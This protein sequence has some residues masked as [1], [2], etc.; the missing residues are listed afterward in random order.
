MCSAGRFEIWFYFSMAKSSFEPIAGISS[1]KFTFGHRFLGKSKIEIQ[2]FSDYSKKLRENGV[3][4]RFVDRTEKISK[5]LIHEA[6]KSGGTLAEDPDLLRIMA[7][8]VEYPE[9]LKGS[10]SPD[11]L[12]LPKEI[13]INAM[14]KHQKYF[15]ILDSARFLTT[16]ILNCLEHACY[17]PRL[18]SG[19]P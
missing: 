10:F 5:D 18:H 15:C 17:E 12:Y 14:R 8:E 7:N 19:R 1:G 9:I 2:A 3:I 16:G 13:L 4:L 11:F 6:Q